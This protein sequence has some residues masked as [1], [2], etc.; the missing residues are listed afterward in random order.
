MGK[1][2]YPSNYGGGGDLH[3]SMRR[4]VVFVIRI[5]PYFTRTSNSTRDT[6]CNCNIGWEDLHAGRRHRRQ[7]VLQVLSHDAPLFPRGSID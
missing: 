4:M 5:I 6:Y 2:A 3:G 7:K 1:E